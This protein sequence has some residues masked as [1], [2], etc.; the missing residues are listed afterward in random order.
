MLAII[1]EEEGKTLKDG[2]KRAW[3]VRILLFNRQNT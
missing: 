1:L 3:M 2:E